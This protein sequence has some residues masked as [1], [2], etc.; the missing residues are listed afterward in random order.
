MPSKKRKRVKKGGGKARRSRYVGVSWHKAGQK[1]RAQI[2]VAGV[3]QYLGSFDDEADGARA[4]DAAVAARNLPNPRN[5]PHNPGAKQATK[6]RD[7]VSAIPDKGKSRFIC[8]SWN[9]R[10]KKWKVRT[11]VKG[12]TE[13]IGVYDDETA[14]AWAYDAYVLTNNIIKNLNFPDTPAAARHMPTKQSSRHHGV[15][16]NKCMKKWVARISVKSKSKSLGYYSDEDAVG[17]GY[18]AAARKYYRDEKPAR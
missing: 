13:Y 2:G 8:V 18:D 4:Y 9:K 1:W 10:S 12:K 16:W 3:E 14:A 11:K 7:N 6:R 15:C 17:R 5:F